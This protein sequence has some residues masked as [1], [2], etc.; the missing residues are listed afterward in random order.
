VAHA[1]RDQEDGTIL[2]ET[3]HLLW[4]KGGTPYPGPWQEAHAHVNGL[5]RRCFAGYSDWRLPT[6]DEL[7]SLFRADMSPGQFCLEPVFDPVQQ[8]IW[9]AD[10]K[11]YVAA[12]YADADMG[13]VWWQDFTCYF[14][15][16]GV[17]TAA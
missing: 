16:R 3:T 2:D 14:Y 1:F 17:R 12:W 11:S 7:M 13:F 5:N 8:R 9:S 10:R 6:V 4:E 15:A